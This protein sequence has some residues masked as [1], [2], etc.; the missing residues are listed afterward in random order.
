MLAMNNVKIMKNIRKW[1]RHLKYM[2]ISSTDVYTH[3]LT[4]EY[5]TY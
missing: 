2:S 5:E 4:A 1:A 3:N